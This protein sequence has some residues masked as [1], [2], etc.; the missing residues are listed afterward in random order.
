MASVGR[1][2]RSEPPW[3]WR[4]GGLKKLGFLEGRGTN[5]AHAFLLLVE[6]TASRCQ[7][8]ALREE[9]KR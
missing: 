1:R 8:I 9:N 7:S 3:I 5:V 4:K 2:K 6:Q